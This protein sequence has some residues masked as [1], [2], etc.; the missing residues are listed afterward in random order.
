MNNRLT[1]ACLLLL[2][3]AAA[4][5]PQAALSR[6]ANDQQGVYRM[7]EVVVTGE[8][9]GVE[10]VGAVREITADEISNRGA[11]TLADALQLMPGLH[12]RTAARGAPRVD[13]RG[14]RTRHVILL[15][16]GV[17]FNSTLD[18]Q[19]DPSMISVENIAKIK[20]SYGNHS[21]LYGE[22]GIG[23]VINIVTKKG[24]EGLRG[25]I[26]G[27]IGER[28][29]YQ[30]TFNVSG[31]QEKIDFFV[32]GRAFDSDGFGLSGDFDPTPEQGK[33]L[34]VNSDRENYTLF[35]NL[36]VTPRDDLLAGFI[37]H[38]VHGTSGAPPSTIDGGD[39]AQ[40]LRHD[41]TEDLEGYTGQ[42][43]LQYNPSPAFELRT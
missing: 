9:D 33:G 7:G 13:M 8:R 15:L 23:G 14:M 27:E 31:A 32:S 16:D 20:V 11:R 24:Q 19:F 3:L 34:R 40:R 10:S 35:A 43:S 1:T 6:P 30:G 26:G 42:V 28:N 41:R 21:V 18:G 25:M 37:F 29:T 5:F 22:G 36:G 4:L 2:L 39:F 38:T 17:P 12:L